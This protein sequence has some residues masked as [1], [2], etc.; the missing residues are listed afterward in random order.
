MYL[1]I[2]A[3]MMGLS[4]ELFELWGGGTAILSPRDLEPKQIEKFGQELTQL[5][6]DVLVDP[7][8]FLLLPFY[9]MAQVF[10]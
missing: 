2:G 10:L 6:G 3:K 9:Q 8:F 5:K 4:R 7:Q 1:Q